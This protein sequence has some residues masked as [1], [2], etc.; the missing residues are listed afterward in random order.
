MRVKRIKKLLI[1]CTAVKIPS[2]ERGNASVKRDWKQPWK[3]DRIPVQRANW[4][5]GKKCIW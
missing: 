4:M 2:V 5:M 1:C 3:I